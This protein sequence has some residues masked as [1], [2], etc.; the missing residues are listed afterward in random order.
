MPSGDS[1]GIQYSAWVETTEAFSMTVKELVVQTTLMAVVLAAG[2]FSIRAQPG[3]LETGRNRVL[4]WNQ[5]P[6]KVYCTLS[7]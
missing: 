1:S 5:L 7:G 2:T 6:G 4:I 3:N